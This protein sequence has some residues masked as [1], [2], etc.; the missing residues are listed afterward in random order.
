MLEPIRTDSSATPTPWA[1]ALLA[2]ACRNAYGL[3]YSTP[4]FA[5]LSFSDRPQLL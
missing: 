2:N 3:R 4:A 5:H 1:A